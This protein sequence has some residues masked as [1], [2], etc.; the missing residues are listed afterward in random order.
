MLG[1]IAT[2][3]MCIT[4]IRPPGPHEWH[5]HT[6]THTHTYAHAAHTQVSL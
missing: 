1:M 5:T 3:N 6:H 4:F 2:A